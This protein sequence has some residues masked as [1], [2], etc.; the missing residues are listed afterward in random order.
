MYCILLID[1]N[2]V[3]VQVQ[4]FYLSGAQS[5]TRLDWALKFLRQ[6]NASTWHNITYKYTEQIYI[7]AELR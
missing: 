4:V 6:D 5:N 1:Y 2:W 7:Y 3:Q